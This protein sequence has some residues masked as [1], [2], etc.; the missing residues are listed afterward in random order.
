MRIMHVITTLGTGG[1]ERHLLSLIRGQIKAG[2]SVSVV[3]LKDPDELR[4][5]FIEVSAHPVVK[6]AFETA[7]QM[8]SC[9]RKIRSCIEGWRPDVVHTHLLKANVIGGLA[10]YLSRP[11]PVII[12]S[13][14]NDD[15]VLR[16]PLT[17]ILHG[18]LSALCD[19]H[20]ITLSDHVLEFTHRHGFIPRRKLTRVHYCFDTH[21]Y[22][23][24]RSVSSIKESLNIPSNAFVFGIIARVT[25]QK[26][27]LF[28]IAA[29]AKL[30]RKYPKAHLLL[31]GGP[32]FN[33]KYLNRVKNDIERHRLHSVIHL[34]GFRPDAFEVMGEL[35]CLLLPS[36]WEGFGMVL[37]EAMYQNVPVVA[38]RAG[39][40]PEVIRDGIDGILANP[41]DADS[42]AAAMGEM[43][44]NHHKYHQ[45][46]A[47]MGESSV[48]TRFPLDHMV[49][50]TLA[51][52]AQ[53]TDHLG[54]A[55]I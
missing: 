35:D 52:Y 44:S 3:Y 25:E 37:L 18:A 11:R 31:I 21:L 5:K 48:L 40:I 36:L 47:K 4:S 6:I 32:G 41:G 7:R 15:P 17:G 10:A 55:N 16:N 34:L 23:E 39:A 27:Q 1:A 8:G 45:K 9:I 26:G 54:S 12:A 20:V 19:T 13:K 22:D 51:V 30:C 46:L 43:I 50:Q 24:R 28:A 29:M 49:E 14:H 42:L 38:T 2:A 53:A 33:D